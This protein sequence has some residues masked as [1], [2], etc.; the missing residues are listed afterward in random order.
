L[1]CQKGNGRGAGEW[2]LLHAITIKWG[3]LDQGQDGCLHFMDGVAFETRDG[4]HKS[5]QRGRGVEEK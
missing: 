4:D 1:G 2:N 5:V 3:G